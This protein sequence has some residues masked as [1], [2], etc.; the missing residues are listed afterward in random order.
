MRISVYF[1]LNTCVSYALDDDVFHAL[2]QTKIYS[3]YRFATAAEA[4]AAATVQQTPSCT[5]IQMNALYTNKAKRLQFSFFPS[6]SRTQPVCIHCTCFFSARFQLCSQ[7]VC[8][9]AE[10]TLSTKC[11]CLSVRS[12]ARSFTH[13]F[14]PLARSSDLE[15]ALAAVCCFSVLMN[16]NHVHKNYLPL[17][18]FSSRLLCHSCLYFSLYLLFR[19]CACFYVAASSA[20]AYNTL[21]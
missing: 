11:S 12:F 1:F 14:H 15:S 6:P 21:K 20:S 13:L 5:T 4:A 8:Q 7:C 3:F 9:L 16:E 2:S 17:D 19:V 10:L 18:C